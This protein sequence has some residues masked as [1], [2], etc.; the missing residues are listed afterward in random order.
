MSD[1]K[2]ELIMKAM[3]RIYKN[4]Q[5]GLQSISDSSGKFDPKVDVMDTGATSGAEKH[6][7]QIAYADSLLS[8]IENKAKNPQKFSSVSEMSGVISQNMAEKQRAIRA[9]EAA[10]AQESDAPV[11]GVYTDPITGETLAAG[12]RTNTPAAWQEYFGAGNEMQNLNEWRAKASGSSGSGYSTNAKAYT[13]NWKNLTSDPSELADLSDEDNA[14][15]G[16]QFKEALTSSRSSLRT[17]TQSAI[18]AARV[19]TDD[20]AAK[21]AAGV[22]KNRTAAEAAQREANASAISEQQ[23][24]LRQSIAGDQRSLANAGD[25]S[26]ASGRK[27]RTTNAVD[28][29]RPI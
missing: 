28:D 2:T 16:A 23:K 21:Y 6:R 17:A 12:Q 19:S 5:S 22:Q 11:A 20:Y 29:Q 15:Y 26:I 3:D 13:E 9:L 27:V 25:Q 10:K 7:K 4:T 14:K 8:D 24:E 1:Y 18:D